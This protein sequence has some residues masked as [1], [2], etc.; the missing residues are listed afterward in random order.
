MLVLATFSLALNVT[1]HITVLQTRNRFHFTAL[2]AILEVLVLL[3]GFHLFGVFQIGII[4]DMYIPIGQKPPQWIGHIFNIIEG[5]Y[6][7]SVFVLYI[8]AYLFS[9]LRWIYRFYIVLSTITFVQSLMAIVIL[10]RLIPLL[11]TGSKRAL[12]ITLSV[13]FAICFVAAV[14]ACFAVEYIVPFIPLHLPRVFLIVIMHAVFLIIVLT[15]L[16]LWV[17]KG[18]KCC[19]LERRT[20][21]HYWGCGPFWAHCCARCCTHNFGSKR[22][23]RPN[24]DNGQQPLIREDMED[25]KPVSWR[26]DD[27]DRESGGRVIGSKLTSTESHYIINA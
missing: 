27:S 1:I 19:V 23:M 11:P 14:S 21:C 3:I 12:Y 4:K 17:Y 7:M 16:L 24:P 13:Q 15:A 8:M 20:V 26:R 2:S 9:D 25:A 18:G 10:W 22:R 5:L 6:F